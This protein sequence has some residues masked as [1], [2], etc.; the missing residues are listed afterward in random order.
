V[1]NFAVGTVFGILLLV[2]FGFLFLVSGAMPVATAGPP[3]PGERWVTQLAL[4]AALRGH[5]DVQPPIGENEVLLLAGAK[6]Y[7]MNCAICHGLPKS[8]ATFIALGLFP[9]PPQF[10]EAEEGVSDDPIGQIYWFA[11]NGIRLTGMPGFV[12]RLSDTEL[13]QVS[14]FL[15]DGDRLPVS[16]NTFLTEAVQNSK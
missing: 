11:K 1:K 6:I 13:W 5:R 10:F 14:Q 7:K 8:S 3:L 12:N 15:K 2:T 16:V 9:K 4:R